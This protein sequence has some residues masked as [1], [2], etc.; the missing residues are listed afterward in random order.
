[1]KLRLF[2]W[3]VILQ[4]F[5]Y[6]E[7]QW[8]DWW[9]VQHGSGV[10]EACCNSQGNNEGTDD[11]TVST[12]IGLQIRPNIPSLSDMSV[13]TIG[14]IKIYISLYDFMFASYPLAKIWI[15]AILLSY[16]PKYN[17]QPSCLPI[18]QVMIDVHLAFQMAK[19]WL[20]TILPSYWPRY[21]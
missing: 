10:G 20:T 21:Y 17:W 15:M 11:G 2:A 7:M 19:I 13:G 1:M 8:D 3:S 18:G 4:I 6:E 14:H 9:K 16:W 12:N 5:V